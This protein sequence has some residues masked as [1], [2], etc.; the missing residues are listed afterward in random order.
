MLFEP[1]TVRGIEA[2]AV[3]VGIH[4]SLKCIVMIQVQNVLNSISNDKQAMK[5]DFKS[6]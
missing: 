1:L 5:T 4:C 6:L 2:M 3:S